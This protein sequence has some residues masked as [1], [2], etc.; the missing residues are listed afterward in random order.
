MFG[1]VSAMQTLHVC[2]SAS[3]SL[4]LHVHCPSFAKF[5][6]NVTYGGDAIC[7]ILPVL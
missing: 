5:S 2:F 7:Y 4:E 3:V 6:V 1:C